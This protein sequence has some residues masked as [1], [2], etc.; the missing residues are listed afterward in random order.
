MNA[1]APLPALNSTRRWDR[2][3]Q[4]LHKALSQS[5]DHLLNG[6]TADGTADQESKT[7]PMQEIL[8]SIYTSEELD[9]FAQDGSS[10][11]FSTRP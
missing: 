7:S 1:T 3:L 9:I 10:S 8:T 6:V 5:R 11:A 4:V 2:V